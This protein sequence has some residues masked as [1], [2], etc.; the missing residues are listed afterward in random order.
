[1]GDSTKHTKLLNVGVI[2]RIEPVLYNK[3]KQRQG[4]SEKITRLQKSIAF[5][6]ALKMRHKAKWGIAL[7]MIIT[8]LKAKAESVG[9]KT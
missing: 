2:L 4:L 1:M 6:K 7:K 5:K 3:K 8:P 9:V